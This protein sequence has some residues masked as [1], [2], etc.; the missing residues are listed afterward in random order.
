M[1]VADLDSFKDVNDRLGHAT[2]DRVLVDA[3]ERL[4]EA[5]RAGDVVARLGGDEFALLLPGTDL[6][7]AARPRQA[8]RARPL[9]AAAGA[10]A[11][12]SA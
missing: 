2:G 3:G 6:A 1:L 10:R 11:S 5:R 7:G 12:P 4:R 8:A 9:R